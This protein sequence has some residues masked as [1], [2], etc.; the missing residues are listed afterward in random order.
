VINL[1]FFRIDFADKIDKINKSAPYIKLEKAIEDNKQ[2]ILRLTQKNNPTA[3]QMVTI[4]WLRDE[5]EQLIREL[6]SEIQC[7]QK[8]TP[9]N[10]TRECQFV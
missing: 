10:R 2:T 9:C 4:S 1:F 5:A 3:D 7:E 8:T 6:T